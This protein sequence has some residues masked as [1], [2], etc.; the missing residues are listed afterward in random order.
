[1]KNRLSLT[2]GALL[3]GCVCSIKAN[4]REDLKEANEI[5]DEKWVEKAK[6]FIE[7]FEK[8][9]LQL[10]FFWR[11][12]VGDGAIKAY[13]WN[14]ISDG[15]TWYRAKGF[16]KRDCPIVLHFWLNGHIE[17][18]VRKISAYHEEI[19]ELSVE[20]CT[21][22]SSNFTDK[23][24]RKAKKKFKSYIT[25]LFEE[26]KLEAC[27]NFLNENFCKPVSNLIIKTIEELKE[28][29]VLQK[30]DLEIL[31]QLYG[32]YNC[33]D[34]FEFPFVAQENYNTTTEEICTLVSDCCYDMSKLDSKCKDWIV[35]LFRNYDRDPYKEGAG[36][37]QYNLDLTIILRKFISKFKME[38]KILDA[39]FTKIIS[40][41]IEEWHQQFLKVENAERNTNVLHAWNQACASLHNAIYN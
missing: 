26:K 17:K 15:G 36:I 32:T 16:F 13:P 9:K 20:H 24:F 5:P 12:Q 6:K 41:V 23:K 7:A 29:E 8:L 21:P 22:V 4:I 3:L 14:G 39:E 1:M 2:V 28:R 33:L 25:N 34:V 11:K 30:Q 10:Q 27:A 37:G 18:Y 31:F 19:Y 35:D 40:V 38:P